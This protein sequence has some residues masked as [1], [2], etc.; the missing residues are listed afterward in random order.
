MYILS[1][2]VSKNNIYTPI[3]NIKKDMIIDAIESLPCRCP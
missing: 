2:F 1:V 3:P